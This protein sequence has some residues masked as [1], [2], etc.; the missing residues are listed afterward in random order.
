VG[1]PPCI[2]KVSHRSAPGNRE[3][4]IWF[5]F[6]DRRSE[7]NDRVFGSGNLQRL[8]EKPDNRKSYDAVLLFKSRIFN[9]CLLGFR[10]LHLDGDSLKV[11]RVNGCDS[12]D[13]ADLT[14]SRSG[15]PSL[16]LC[17]FCFRVLV[18]L[19]MDATSDGRAGDGMI[20]SH[21]QSLDRVAVWE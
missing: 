8:I 7:I 21:M 5:A 13:T 1:S 3:L 17:R 14:C 16:L 10:Q 11:C 19:L 15:R 9:Q 2:L 4:R 18:F 12:L 20:R 6:L